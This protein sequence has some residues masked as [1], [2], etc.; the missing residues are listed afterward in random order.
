M[1]S[2]ALARNSNLSETVL[3]RQ[4][5]VSPQIHL[6]AIDPADRP[7]LVKLLNDREIY[8][9]TLRIPHPYSDEDAEK[10]LS[11]VDRTTCQYGQP[12]HFGVRQT[13]RQL[14]GGC[15][16]EH[17]APGHCAELGYWLA[18]PYWG[19]GIMTQVVDALCRFAVSE[20]KLVRI[21]AQVFDT[22]TASIRVLEKNGFQQEGH[23]RKAYRKDGRFIDARLYALVF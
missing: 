15:G 8:D 3:P 9:Q 1:R 6:S 20:W 22:N 18:R 5:F 11:I 21:T 16:F 7:A 10:F 14:L 13:D 17:L 4:I 19:R 2:K 12:V 23:L